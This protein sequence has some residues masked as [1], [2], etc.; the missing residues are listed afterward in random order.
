[1]KHQAVKQPYNHSI[2]NQQQALNTYMLSV[3]QGYTSMF[4]TYTFV[5][6]LNTV[7]QT[8]NKALNSKQQQKTHQTSNTK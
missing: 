3:D 4:S 2:S 6:M 1:M 7:H 5:L 8:P